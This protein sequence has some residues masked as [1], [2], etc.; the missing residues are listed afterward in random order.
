MSI[1][2]PSIKSLKRL[3][4]S[5]DDTKLIRQ[6]FEYLGGKKPIQ[7]SPFPAGVED[8]AMSCYNSP[9]IADVV[10]AVIASIITDGRDNS[11]SIYAPSNQDEWRSYAH[12]PEWSAVNVGDPYVPTI[13][14]TP[15]GSYRVA[16]WGDIK[17]FCE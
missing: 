15:S 5:Y 16:C 14:K 4:L 6:W 7:P 9:K 1:S 13:V 2:I 12:G 3:N 17:A 11:F 8:W 10:E